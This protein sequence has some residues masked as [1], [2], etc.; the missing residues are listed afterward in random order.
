MECAGNKGS[1][2]KT[3][4]VCLCEKRDEYEW[5]GVESN[6]NNS[7]AFVHTHNK[8]G[9]STNVRTIVINC[10]VIAQSFVNVRSRL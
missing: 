4:R 5:N 1:G 9:K 10:I 6:C 8:S 2:N 7:N 3:V